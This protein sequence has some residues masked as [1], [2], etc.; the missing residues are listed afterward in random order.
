MFEILVL[1]VGLAMDALA[2]ALVRGSVGRHQPLRAL[3]VGLAFGLAQGLMP[4]LGWGVSLVFAGAV[5]AFDHWLAFVLLSALGVR[6]L[7]EAWRGD[8]EGGGE[9]TAAAGPRRSYYFGLLM[10]ALAT[11]VDAAA[12]GLT[13]PLLDV[14]IAVSCL[15]IGGV[16]AVLCT[17]GYWLGVRATPR[18]GKRAEV[19]G[20]VVLIALGVKIL[21]EHL[22]A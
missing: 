7:Y 16:T 5:E 10:A 20:G 8:G 17:A 9:G 18:S 4:L 22:G 13:L 15:V 19:V 1:S 6:M 2:V 3:E 12:A 21:V 14:P 11:S